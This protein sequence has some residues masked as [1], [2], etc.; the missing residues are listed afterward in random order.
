MMRLLQWLFW[1]HVHQWETIGVGNVTD[2]GHIIGLWFHE[3]CTK[4]GHNRY[5]KEAS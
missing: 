2:M 4:C 5:R 1:G 3:R